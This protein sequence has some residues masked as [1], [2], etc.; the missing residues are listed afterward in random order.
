M[1]DCDGLGAAEPG[2]LVI[3]G[4]GPKVPSARFNVGAVSRVVGLGFGALI[5]QSNSHTLTLINQSNNG[6]RGAQT[7]QRKRKSEGQKIEL[8]E[9][10]I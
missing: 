8:E 7:E 4:G 3:A 10:V 6:E 9:R 1:E 2:R 5:C